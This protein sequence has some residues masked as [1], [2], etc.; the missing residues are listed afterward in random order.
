MPAVN[1]SEALDYIDK[2][3]SAFGVDPSTAKS[4]LLSEN[5][6]DEAI[7]K[8][9][10]DPKKYNLDDSRTSPK[11]AQGLMQVM[12]GTLQGLK[13]QGFVKQ[14][15]NMESWQ[16]QVDAGLAALQ[17][18][19]KRTG[20]DDPDH[21]AASYNA[22]PKGGQAYEAG[23]QLPA[24]T[25][26]YL[27]KMRL[28]REGLNGPLSATQ[29]SVRKF[30]PVEPGSGLPGA[31]DVGGGTGGNG[32]KRQS[33]TS[34]TGI[35]ALEDLVRNNGIYTEQLID[36]ITSSTETEAA[37]HLQAGA[38]IQA[39]GKATA[40]AAEAKGVIEAAAVQTRDRIL[41]LVGLDTR[42]A[43]N[44]V[45]ESIAE[46][47]TSEKERK[48]LAADIKERMSVGFFDNPIQW[49]V[50]ETILPGAVNR[51]NALLREGNIALENLQTAQQIAAKQETIDMSAT[52]DMI[53]RQSQAIGN[54]AVANANATNAEYK[55]K[56]ASAT[57]RAATSIAS[58]AGRQIDDEIKLVQMRKIVEST[59]PED[60]R[61][62]EEQKDD[63]ALDTNIRR[64]G[65]M[66]GAVNA[67]LQT[68][69]RMSK[70]DQTEWLNRVSK[71]N[72]GDDFYEA[73]TFLRKYG[74]LNNMQAT[75]S[76]ELAELVARL[77]KSVT[78]NAQIKGR[79]MQA[80]GGGRIPSVEQLRQI[81]SNEMEL[82]WFAT[83]DN[84]LL[85]EPTNPYLINH[86]IM[87]TAFK[88]DY[89]KNVVAKMVRDSYKNKVT[90]N[91]Q[92]LFTSVTKLID[93]GQL[94]PK[95]AAAQ[96]AEYY[97]DAVKRNNKARSYTLI[98]L[99]SQD[100]YKILPSESKMNMNLL[101]ALQTENFLTQRAIFNQRMREDFRGFSKFG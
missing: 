56:S 9:L 34:F 7:P 41:Q 19:R 98:G 35:D 21:L 52:V 48:V 84:M 31:S 20:K 61:R 53:A 44:K 80:E 54:A 49:L 18:I 24:E 33:I 87:A 45:A 16:E 13:E 3:A 27:T 73:M 66:I 5:F 42:N 76:A 69:K 50:N 62:L 71:N 23:T 51:H 14:N 38:A 36:D 59:K 96:L 90:L 47:Q 60:Q 100:D 37:A 93:A 81:V 8:A 2:Q 12:P 15:N 29:G 40:D 72:I 89:E 57:A 58:L 30:E 1:L 55:A 64:I 82:K 22:G 91:D 92:Q 28:A 79:M 86:G 101:N 78:D 6:N 32:G 70:Q 97:G 67:N 95:D 11:G 75:G 4:I 39:A 74:N 99:P 10:Q 63:E 68:V 43:D 85:A 77:N 25:T 83:R 65:T 46:F 94:T 88:G 26:N 17:E